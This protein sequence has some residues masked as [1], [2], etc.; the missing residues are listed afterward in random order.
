MP[1][2]VF[3][4]SATSLRRAALALAMLGLLAGAGGCHRRADACHAKTG[5]GICVDN[6]AA[7]AGAP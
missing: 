4:R 1:E 7:P 2:P 5:D 3:H 6:D